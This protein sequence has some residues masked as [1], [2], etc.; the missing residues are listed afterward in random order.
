MMERK[1][2]IHK[3]DTLKEAVAIAHKVDYLLIKL[4]VFIRRFYFMCFSANT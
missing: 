3:D 1:L 2:E 4:L